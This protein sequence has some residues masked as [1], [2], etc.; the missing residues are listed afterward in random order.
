MKLFY[1]SNCMEVKVYMRERDFFKFDTSN[2][3]RN[4]NG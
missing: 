2:L 3:W 4:I 1:N